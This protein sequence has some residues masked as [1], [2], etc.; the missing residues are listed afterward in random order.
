MCIGESVGGISRPAASS[1]L[2]DA[3][4][5]IASYGGDL[6]RFATALVGPS[7]A[8]DLV[9]DCV[10]RLL[11]SD[12][13][14]SAQDVRSYLYRSLLNQ[15]RS[16]HRAAYRRG[17]RERASAELAVGWWDEVGPR[18]ELLD[19][20]SR[21]SPRRRGVLFAVYWLDL[22]TE[23]AASLLG[24]STRTLERELRASK[25]LLKEVLS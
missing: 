25:A 8:P 15:A 7:E 6:L 5:V 18:V 11:R 17:L 9:A 21:L 14:A 16:N 24:I 20:V 13:L 1:T 12:R 19:A 2:M 4:H 3:S 22:D 23:G 10:V